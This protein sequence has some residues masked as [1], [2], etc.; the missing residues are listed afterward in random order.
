M[1]NPSRRVVLAGLAASPILARPAFAQS[2]QRAESLVQQLVAEITRIINSG[3]SEQ[4]MFGSFQQLF[5]RYADVPTIARF[6]LG[7]DA[8]SAS[9]AQL[10]AY[11]DAFGGYIARKYGKRFRE[12]IGGTITVQGSR[13]DKSFV[14]V[15]TTANLRGKSPFAVDFLVSD[16]S[17]SDRFFNVIIEGINMLTTER[18]EIGAMLDQSGGNIDALTQRLRSAG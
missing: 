17:G 5:A 15:Q 10:R 7:A 3:Q 14:V 13:V 12:F 6:S 2:T 9:N 16:R 1:N 4:Q 8:R 11:Q 18:T